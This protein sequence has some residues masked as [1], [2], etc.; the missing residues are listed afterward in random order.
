MP[1]PIS[2]IVPVSAASPVADAVSPDLVLQAGSV[3][4]ARVVSVLADNLVRI[5]IANLSMDVISEVALAPDLELAVSQN[6]GTIRLAVMGGAGEATAD[7]VTL[8]PAAASLVDSPPIAPSASAGRNVLTPSE[9][10]AVT[11]ASAEAVT[12]QGSQAPLFAN[13]AAVV[14]GSDLPAGLKQAMLGVLAQQTPLNT[15][16]DGGD[17]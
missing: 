4:D 5:A 12:K 6:G 3:V 13:L 9:Q 2:S 10:V 11:A 7:Q 8:T 16:L 15:G 17:I 1:T 14:T